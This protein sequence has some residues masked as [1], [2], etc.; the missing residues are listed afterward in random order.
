MGPEDWHRIAST[1][2]KHYDNFDGFV[3]VMGTDTLQVARRA[4][5]A[6]ITRRFPLI[7]S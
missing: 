5:D 4:D 2:E 3:V 1:I 7:C 6:A